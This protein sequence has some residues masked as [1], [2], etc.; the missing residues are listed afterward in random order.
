MVV[1]RAPELPQP[2]QDEEMLTPH[3][4]VVE[5][6]RQDVVEGP[7]QD[8]VEGPQ[9]MEESASTVENQLMPD[10]STSR[11][12]WSIENFFKRNVRKHYSDDF[13]VGGYKWR[14]LVF[15][16][17]N[18]TDHLS[19]YL[20]VA[21]SHLLPP[22]WSRYAQFSLAVV[23][24]L[25]SKMSIRKEATHQFNARESDWGFT[26][27]MPLM[28]LCDFSKGYVV[29]DKC[30]I[31]AEVAVRKIFDVWNHDSKKMTG[32]VGLKNQ[33]AT[34]Y[35][36]SLLQT[37]YHIP[38]F[39]K[40]VYHMPTT[41]N[42]TPSGS[43]PLALQSLF[44]KLQHSDNS[45]ATKEL[46]K[47][48]GWDSYD[49]FMQHDVQELNR[50]L[51]EKLENKMKGTTVEGAIQ[52]LF[53]G[54]HKNYIECINVDYKST[55]KESFYDL[56]L[57][58]K[59]CSD[60]YASF[61]K[62]VAVERLEGD[63][64]YQCEEHGL[65][66]AKK[67]MLFIDF[68]PVLQ[69]QLKRFEYDFVRDAMVKINDRY[70]FPL[71]LD[72]D[73]DDGKY[74][75][76]EADRSVRNLY[77]L[78]SVLVHSGGVHGGHYYA[79]IRPTL[80]DQWYKFDDERVTKEDMKRALEEQYGGEEELPHTNP[81]L[82]T[83][84]LRFTKHSNAYMLVYI[85]E[86]DK[87]KII[88]N[89][90][91]ED[92]SEHLKVRLRKEQ[93]EKEYKK[94]EKAEAHMFTALK[95]ARD[96]DLKEQIGRHVHFDLVDFDKINSYRAPKDISIKDIKVELSKEFGIPV[97]SQIFWVWAKRQ[98]GTYRPSR[99]LTWQEERAAIGTLKDAIT[100]SKLQTSEVRLFLEFHCR[101]ENEPI[102]R[103]L[104]TKEDILL[105]FKF[106]DPEKEYLRY[107]GNFFVK[108]SGKPSD[109]VER[110][111][112]IAGF[113]S[114]EDIELYE[115]IKFEPIVMCEPIDSNASFHSS[116]ISD[117]DIICY[118]KRCLPDKMDQYRYPTVSSFFEYIHDK[119][120][121]RFRLLEKPKEDVFSLELS[122]RF[123]YDDVVEKVAHQLGLDEPSKIRLTQH[124]PYSHQPKPHHIKYRGVNYLSDMLQHHTQM[125]DILY[126]ETLDIPLPELE[127]L[128]TLRVAFQNAANYEV[129]F[130]I[131][132][133]P[134]SN[135]L[136]D[137][138][139]DL[140]SK[141]ELSCNHA[142]FRLFEVYLH[143]IC[144]VYQPGD[145]IDSVND[146]YGPLRIEEV[147][148]EE[149]NAGP[150]DRLVHVYHFFKDNHHNQ[151]FGEPFFFLI[152]D[153]EVLA[154]IKV[155]IQKRLRIPD[156]QFLKWKFACVTYSQTEYL[157]D[158]D[159]VLSRFQ[160]QKP[161]Y[162]A[163]EHHLGLEHTATTPKRS[164]LAS[165]NRHSFEKPVKIYN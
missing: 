95:V 50:I 39:R 56:A 30:I 60:V 105:F 130:H 148:E 127:G 66:D 3:Q 164:F 153:G 83:T 98:N 100:I 143:K 138:I 88:C 51:C 82:N 65:Q 150:Q 154:D 25:D 32:Y 119:Q 41:E 58:V 96:S 136:F 75:S 16:R 107:V 13:V 35:M 99:P 124:N 165:Q 46:T 147:P 133:S 93:E 63:N 104:K 94:K 146:Q 52:K 118:Q 67:G 57:D 156:E 163:W 101:Q 1:P 38:Y 137:L 14:V 17:G 91:E 157:Q 72:L 149:K 10:P 155:R 113:P 132:R 54:H 22:G 40:A 110:L 145:T 53:E 34:C 62:Y 102:V 111:N 141:V 36:N 106:Y 134:K 131:M 125:C 103:P 76:P 18:N 162:G 26:S 77:T 61:D 27:F 122:K 142:E 31:E 47:S 11:F 33:G 151:Y 116:Q 139:E 85:R 49:S 126:Y 59:G 81:G 159:V 29:N 9:P 89:L 5:G 21:D 161:V 44:Y 19:M 158:S 6:P 160:K 114:D 112:E 45:V 70:V 15:P 24:Q 84:P 28:D 69:L 135:T 120:V 2:D 129:S 23:N 73:K 80:S 79:F 12:T 64:K 4:E 7:Q 71:Q 109:I 152:R 43:I 87:E 90:D 48:F 121:V 97:E 123:T 68:P 140:K 144:K 37:L 117:G 86:S 20:D 8:V 128:K 115:E 55:R 42:D 108:A 78:H 92:I 74:L